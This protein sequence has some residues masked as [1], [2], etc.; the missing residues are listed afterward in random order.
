M[1]R[2]IRKGDREVDY[3][4]AR[5][6]VEAAKERRAAQ[7]RGDLQRRAP[8]APTTI[9]TASQPVNVTTTIM[10]P[11]ITTTESVLLT[12][13]S[14]FTV[15]APT[16]LS[17]LITR[18]TTL[19]TPTKTKTYLDFTTTTKVLTIGAKLTRTTTVTP[20]ATLIACKK[21][22]GHFWR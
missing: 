13:S 22:G 2:F 11:A 1:H 8:D 4:W 12:A 7:A 18:T 5:A 6:R 14:T 9:L 3:E 10:A 20:A 19:P 21:E 16:V 15:P 17:G